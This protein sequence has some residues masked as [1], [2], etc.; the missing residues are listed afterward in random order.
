METVDQYQ[1]TLAK[2]ESLPLCG[3]VLKFHAENPGVYE[4][5]KRFGIEAG[6]SGR[7]RF[8][9]GMI[10]ERMRW[11]T[12]IETTEFEFKLNDHHRAFYARLFAHEYPCYKDLFVLR[13]SEADKLDYNN[14]EEE[15]N[16]N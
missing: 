11:Y 12:K 4:L 13:E 14:L 1:L 9:I 6:N 3:A 10:W 5:V 8:G 15:A 7:K 2:T 16:W